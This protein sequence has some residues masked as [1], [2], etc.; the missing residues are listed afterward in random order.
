MRIAFFGT[1]AF[2]V[3]TLQCLLQSTHDV[4]AVVTQPD[5]ARGRGQH[6]SAS[7]V[8]ELAAP[9]GLAILQPEQVKD[10]A[11]AARLADLR[12]DLG[13]VA[14]Y[15]QLLPDALLSVPRHGMIN[16]HASLLPR[17]RGAAPI[18]RAVMA[19]ET[20][21]GVTIIQLVRKMDAG[22]M[23][24]SAPRAIHPAETSDDVARDLA[25][26]GARLLMATVEDI[27]GGRAEPQPQDHS[28]AT[29]AP[30]LTRADGII[31]W[32]TS[33]ITIHN[34]VR[35][36]LPWPQACTAVDGMRHLVSSTTA[37]PWP[38]H[39]AAMKPCPG[40]T[41]LEAARDRLIVAAGDS[42]VRAADD[43]VIA[44]HEIQLEGRRRMSVR[45]FLAG[46]PLA[47]GT[48]LR[49]PAA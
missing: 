23:L 31:D 43:R 45:A 15:G 24:R 40:G 17:Y 28:R 36:L 48:V 26:L 46:H 10:A 38:V 6:V 2:A 13:V 20:R 16:V 35:G 49:S 44:I 9:H 3:P 30:R 41:V 25:I 14:A 34:Q 27:A 19:G 18:Q 32:N 47:P 29:Y 4:V 5:R 42:V 33:A 22:P 1:P 39:L 21:T 12:P 11:F 37:V 7:P 8:R